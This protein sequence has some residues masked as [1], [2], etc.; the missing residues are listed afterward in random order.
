MVIRMG[1]LM[2]ILMEVL[3]GIRMDIRSTEARSLLVEN[4]VLVFG[5]GNTLPVLLTFMPTVGEDIPVGRSMATVLLE[6]DP[7]ADHTP[8]VAEE[9]L[10]RVQVSMESLHRREPVHPTVSVRTESPLLR[11][12][13]T[14]SAE[15]EAP[16]LHVGLILSVER[17]N[18]P[19]M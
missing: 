1:I 7:P 10:T 14:V 16:R 18:L 8:S 3:T 11:A 19:V 17:T 5:E 4:S 13:P 15:A 12:G 6:L 9:D 2:D